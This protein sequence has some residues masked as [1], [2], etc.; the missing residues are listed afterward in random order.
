M[1]DMDDALTLGL[2]ESLNALNVLLKVR[3]VLLCCPPLSLHI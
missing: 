2:G 3:F 1:R